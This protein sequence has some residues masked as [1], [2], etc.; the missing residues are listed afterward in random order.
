[1]K[2]AMLDFRPI[3]IR[4]DGPSAGTAPDPVNAPLV[5]SGRL[6]GGNEY[7]LLEN[8]TMIRPDDEALNHDCQSWWRMDSHLSGK[9]MIGA[10]YTNNLFVPMRRPGPRPALTITGLET[11]NNSNQPRGK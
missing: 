11:P 4:P 8:G 3:V 5:G 1:M 2:N 7:H 9:H 10:R 6:V